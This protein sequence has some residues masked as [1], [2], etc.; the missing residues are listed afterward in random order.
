MQL[1]KKITS[2]S[3]RN[4]YQEYNP[5][6]E[7]IS[8]KEITSEQVVTIMATLNISMLMAISGQLLPHTRLGRETKLLEQAIV[9]YAGLN[10]GKLDPELVEVGVEAWNAAVKA[11][12]SGLSRVQPC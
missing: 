11:I 1:Y 8:D 3:G 9:R 12:Q 10:G 2:P 5:A 4:T 7:I 6:I